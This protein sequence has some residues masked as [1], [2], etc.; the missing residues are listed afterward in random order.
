MMKNLKFLAMMFAAALSFAA[1]EPVEGEEFGDGELE[2]K[3]TPSIILCDGEYASTLEATIGG[4]KVTS[5]VS[6]FDNKNNPVELPGMKFTTTKAGTYTFWASYGD[7]ISNEVT[8]TAVVE[9]PAATEIPLDPNPSSTSFVRKVMLTQFTGTNCG[10][11]PF[12]VNCIK[13]LPAAVSKHCILTAAHRFNQDDPAYLTGVALDQTMAV[14]G[15]PTLAVDM[16]SLESDYRYPALIRGMVQSAIDREEAKVG[17]AAC[18]SYNDKSRM[19]AVKAEVKAAVTGNYRIGAWLLE[20]GIYGEQ[21]N[22]GAT[23]YDYD[24]HDN[25]IRIADSRVTGTDYTGYYLGEIKAGEKKVFEFNPTNMILE[26][27][28]KAENC[29]LVIFVTCEGPESPYTENTWYVNN[30]VVCPLNSSVAYQYK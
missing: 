19:V 14:S 15:F 30:V 16:H 5:G 23:G 18:A 12:M 28:W 20:D 24:T 7:K 22:N 27:S 11:C 25:C 6:I 17:I 13:Q 3:A 9:F 1:C 29:R 21:E 8:I 10:F 4:K 2:L 26:K